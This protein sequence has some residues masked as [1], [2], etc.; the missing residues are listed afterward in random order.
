MS[1]REQLPS[2]ELADLA[3]A[4]VFNVP[5]RWQRPSLDDRA[6]LESL[7]GTPLVSS[8]LPDVRGLPARILRSI[9]RAV[10]GTGGHG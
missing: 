10:L 4:G 1:E 8:L 7:R 3:E 5:A 6:R 9:R 2:R